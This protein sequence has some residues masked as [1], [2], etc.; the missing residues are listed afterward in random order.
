MVSIALTTT[1]I[2][3]MEP[4]ATPPA[5]CV[6]AGRGGVGSLVRTDDGGADDG[7][8]FRVVVVVATLSTARESRADSGL[9]TIGPPSA[10]TQAESQN[11]LRT[12]GRGPFASL[13]RAAGPDAPGRRAAAAVPPSDSSQLFWNSG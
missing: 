11:Q 6:W 2:S 7:P 10:L 4:A 13:Q 3:S 1:E 5:V 12:V 9:V 8:R